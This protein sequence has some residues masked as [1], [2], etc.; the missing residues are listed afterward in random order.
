MGYKP[1][2]WY[3]NVSIM[4]GELKP[5]GLDRFQPERPENLSRRGNG[6]YRARAI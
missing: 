3:A 5:I 6:S 1:V 4:P 2:L